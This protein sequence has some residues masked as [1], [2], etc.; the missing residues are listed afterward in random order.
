MLQYIRMKIHRFTHTLCISFLMVVLQSCTHTHTH[1]HYPIFPFTFTF[2]TCTCAYQTST[3]Q[4]HF[5]TVIT[6]LEVHEIV[7]VKTITTEDKWAVQLVNTYTRLAAV[8]A[9]GLE[10]EIS[11]FG[12]LFGND[13]LINGIIDQVQ[14]SLETRELVILD[15]KTRRTNSLPSDAQKMGHSLQLM[16]YK[17][18]LDGLTCGTTNLRL[19]V[20]H[21]NL[22]F[23]RELTRGVIEHIEKCGLS[24]LFPTLTETDYTTSA[25]K[26]SNPPISRKIT[27]EAVADR[28]YMLISGLGLPLVSSMLVQYE[29]QV[30]GEVIGV[31]SVDYDEQWMK[32]MLKS[33]VDFWNGRRPAKGV[34]IED[35]WKC[36]SCQFRDVCV[37]RIQK[38][39]EQS[40]AARVQRSSRSVD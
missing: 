13:I 9:G 2:F 11:V 3:F 36:E 38:G 12:D 30:T 7:R 18:M 20:K 31:E 32:E 23:N 19:L 17:C 21:L 40:P 28:M 1:E 15:N 25:G 37:W 29:Y 8:A 39:L 5:T 16:L 4:S 33:S 24:G 10:R 26:E 35:S 22:D 6:E 27:F 14:Y 34:D